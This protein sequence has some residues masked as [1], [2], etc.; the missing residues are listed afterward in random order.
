MGSRINNYKRLVTKIN[1]VKLK[2]ESFPIL[3]ETQQSH[4][5]KHG[6]FE[7]LGYAHGV[8]RAG[9]KFRVPIRYRII[10]ERTA[11][12]GYH[13]PQNQRHQSKPASATSFWLTVR[14]NIGVREVLP[15]TRNKGLC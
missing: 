7:A 4:R 10:S 12:P 1:N 2:H 15:D 8:G 9:G 6:A 13:G 3:P 5:M 14:G 11:R